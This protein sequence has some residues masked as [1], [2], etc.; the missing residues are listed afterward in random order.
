MRTCGSVSIQIHVAQRRVAKLLRPL[1]N[2]L[3][4][5]H[6]TKALPILL[7]L[8]VSSCG[9]FSEVN[10]NYSKSEATIFYN[11]TVG[12][13]RLNNLPRVTLSINGQKGE[14]LIDSGADG[15]AITQLCVDR[16]G[17]RTSAGEPRDV[18]LNLWGNVIATDI[19][20]DVAVQL[21]PDVTLRWSRV[22]IFRG[23]ILDGIFGILDYNTLRATN[24]L[25]DVRNKTLTF[26]K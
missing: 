11:D 7:P 20:E 13:L 5:A 8:W 15:P 17:I 3:R 21:H 25:I 2:Y 19:A 24:A 9:T 22:V 14:F 26:R 12:P 16:C 4:P 23:K 10:L 18:T 6:M 1:Y